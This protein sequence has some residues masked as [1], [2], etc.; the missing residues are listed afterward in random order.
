MKLL[1]TDEFFAKTSRCYQRSPTALIFITGVLG[2]HL[3]SPALLNSNFLMDDFNVVV[4]QAQAR[5][6]END[7]AS[8]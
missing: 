8:C 5:I 3:T 7:N 1:C 2:A 6:T 4:L